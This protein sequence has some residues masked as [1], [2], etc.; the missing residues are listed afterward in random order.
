MVSDYYCCWSLHS[1]QILDIMFCSSSCCCQ[2]LSEMTSSWCLRC[3]G[4]QL[5][6]SHLSSWLFTSCCLYPDDSWHSHH[7][8]L[9]SQGSLSP[10]NDYRSSLAL[11]FRALL[12]NLKHTDFQRLGWYCMRDTTQD[13]VWTYLVSVNQSLSKKW[14]QAHQIRIPSSNIYVIVVPKVLHQAPNIFSHSQV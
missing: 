8:G 9:L 3:R 12:R 7:P 1:P 14:A 6:W 5:C 10:H 2:N 13:Y 11:R 4:C